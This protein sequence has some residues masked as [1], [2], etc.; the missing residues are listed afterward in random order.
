M[1]AGVMLR[2]AAALAVAVASLAAPAARAGE[3][4]CWVDRGAVVVSARFGDI[5]GDFLLD[6]AAPH[7]ALEADVAALDGID[8]TSAQAELQIGDARRP[9][10]FAVTALDAR[11]LGLPT[12]LNGLIGADALAG[13]VIDLRLAP[14]CRIA[15][16]PRRAP[17][18][19]ALA[20]LP[21]QLVGGVPAAS[22]TASDGERSLTG[23]F[24]VDTGTAAVRL[25]AP[26]AGFSRPLP[27]T[28]DPASR[29]RP[30][31]RL[32]ALTL[33][34]ALFQGVPAAID[35]SLPPGLAGGLGTTVWS[36]YTIRV[37][38]GRR[39]LTLAPP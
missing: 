20:R 26:V 34:G 22:A 27:H 10:T 19:R 39:R 6:L 23:L 17:R 16:W 36:R 9:A 14:R 11:T 15:L 18:L 2:R 37:D 13:W 30:P 3:A 1:V 29:L 28:A 24:A 5:A 4:R 32:A 12:T 8:A 31:A 21:L 7:S 35:P 38:L 33:G 25:A